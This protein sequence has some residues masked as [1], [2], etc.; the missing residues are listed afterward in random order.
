MNSKLKE[1][2]DKWKADS[3]G[4]DSF[5]INQLFFDKKSR[6]WIVGGY[7]FK[8]FNSEDIIEIFGKPNEKVFG[9]EDNCLMMFYIVL[10]KRKLPNT[11]LD[12]DFDKNDKVVFITLCD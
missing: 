2:S 7:N 8:G 10:K 5:R 3:L 4:V 1:F 12:F 6:D 9:K 11:M